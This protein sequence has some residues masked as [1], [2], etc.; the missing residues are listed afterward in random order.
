MAIETSGGI[1]TAVGRLC[2]DDDFAATLFG[3]TNSIS[4]PR[5]TTADSESLN[6]LLNEDLGFAIDL[7]SSVYF[8]ILVWKLRNFLGSTIEKVQQRYALALGSNR[9]SDVVRSSNFYAAV[10]LACIDG[11][12][13][14]ELEKGAATRAAF[15]AALAK[16]PGFLPETLE[17][18]VLH[19]LFVDAGFRDAIQET[20]DKGWR[21]PEIPKSAWPKKCKQA[22]RF[23]SEYI[24]IDTPMVINMV[25]SLYLSLNSSTDPDPAAM[26]EKLVAIHSAAEI[27]EDP[28]EQVRV[29][30]E[31]VGFDPTEL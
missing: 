30:A 21:D 8:H 14:D 11:I 5:P 2:I 13:R 16:S 12:Y 4:Q 19:A 29:L 3:V 17:L 6:R 9:L 18:P 10:G 27:L 15:E 22:L 24:Y 20:H 1:W 25:H 7:D 31:A 28:K 23:S 26:R